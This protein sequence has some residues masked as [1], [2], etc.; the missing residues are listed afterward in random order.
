V[1]RLLRV[2][3]RWGSR[4][5]RGLSHSSGEIRKGAIQGRLF[6]CGRCRSRYGAAKELLDVA[7]VRLSEQIVYES[8]AAAHTRGVLLSETGRYAARLELEDERP[9]AVSTLS[10]LSGGDSYRSSRRGKR[11]SY[12]AVGEARAREK[13]SAALI[14]SLTNSHSTA[15]RGTRSYRYG[16]RPLRE[17]TV[18]H[19]REAEELLRRNGWLTFDGGRR[20]EALGTRSVLLVLQRG[21]RE[22]LVV[23]ERTAMI[24][25]NDFAARCLQS[26]R[27]ER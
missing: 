26:L 2:G 25:W 21:D 12:L 10:A 3:R 20:V 4:R 17:R 8:V 11:K 13:D 18:G 9:S 19:T 14:F 16:T 15:A 24:V 7:R 22:H 27:R 6:G 23:T 1:R 5:R